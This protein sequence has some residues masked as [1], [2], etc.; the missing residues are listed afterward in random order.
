MQFGQEHGALDLCHM[1]VERFERREGKQALSKQIEQRLKEIRART[2]W[3][4][5]KNQPE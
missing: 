1:L 5:E 4:E 2:K 3:I